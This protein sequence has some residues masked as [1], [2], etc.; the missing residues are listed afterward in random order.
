VSIGHNAIIHGCTIEDNVLI[1][2]G[3]M[4]LDG[5]VIPPLTMIAAGAL[6]PERKVLESGFLYMGMPAKKV[7]PLSPEQLQFF[8]ERTA[9]NYVKYA[10]WY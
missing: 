9:L 6:V 2:M 8:I 1:G 5:A 10:S 7:K 3:A 4:V